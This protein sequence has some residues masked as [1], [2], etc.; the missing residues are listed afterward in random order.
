MHYRQSRL[1]ED[2]FQHVLTIGQRLVELPFCVRFGLSGLLV[3]EEPIGVYD[4]DIGVSFEN[5]QFLLQFQ[6]VCPKVVASTIGNIFPLCHEQTVEIVVDH[7]FVLLVG[8]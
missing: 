5:S 6:R 3:V 4:G 2:G 1:R 7:S 8:Y